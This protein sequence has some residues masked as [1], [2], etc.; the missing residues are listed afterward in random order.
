[1]R[2]N[3]IEDADAHMETHPEITCA[4]LFLDHYL[5][6]QPRN[7]KAAYFLEILER[8]KHLPLTV[9]WIDNGRKHRL[10]LAPEGAQTRLIECAGLALMVGAGPRVY[11]WLK[12]PGERRQEY[13]LSRDPSMLVAKPVKM[14]VK[15][16]TLLLGIDLLGRMDH[17]PLVM[18]L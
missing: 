12:S 5:Y 9:A 4:G 14:P 3:T 7:D 10:Y 6:L 17:D 2:F 18:P 11:A 8:G 13:A 15:S 16:L 1:M